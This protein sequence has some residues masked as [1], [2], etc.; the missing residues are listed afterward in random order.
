MNQH[1]RKLQNLL[2]NGKVESNDSG[3]VTMTIADLDVP[4]Y[5]PYPVVVLV[6]LDNEN[7][8][9][10]AIELCDIEGESSGY[11]YFSPDLENYASNLGINTQKWY[12]ANVIS[13]LE[14]LN[15]YNGE[16]P[17][18]QEDISKLTINCESYFNRVLA[19]F[20]K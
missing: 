8:K 13:N 2:I 11:V 6:Y 16:A 14:G 20:N 19:S 3:N 15:E 5:E 18:S 17:L 12:Y 10:Y 1:K 4:D 9:G 7:A